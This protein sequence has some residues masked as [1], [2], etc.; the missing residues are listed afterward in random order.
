MVLA[1]SAGNLQFQ[2][3]RFHEYARHKELTLK[4]N[5]TKVM[6]FFSAD[7]TQL[8]TFEYNGT[9]LGVVTEFK[10]LGV[11][12]R[13]DGKMNAATRQMARNFMGGIAR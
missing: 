11:L 12:L 1:N 6:V 5:K 8:P 13:R 3:N 10:Y 9:A 4:T 7:P 2:L